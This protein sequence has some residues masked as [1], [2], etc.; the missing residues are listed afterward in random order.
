MLLNTVPLAIAE[1]KAF[2]IVV[3]VRYE[4]TTSTQVQTRASD[5]Q[6]TKHVV[7]PGDSLIFDFIFFIH[8]TAI[9]H[10]CEMM[11]PLFSILE[12]N[13]SFRRPATNFVLLHLKRWHLM[14]WVRAVMASTLGVE[15]GGALPPIILQQETENVYEQVAQPLE[16][17]PVDTWVRTLA[18]AV[19]CA[20]MWGGIGYWVLISQLLQRVYSGV[21]DSADSPAA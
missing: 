5:L 6:N 7:V 2:S 20:V 17:V 21:L 14:E 19:V 8:P 9:G 18:A 4:H 13:P 10:W 3:V 11:F 16:G 1:S 12:R 15:A